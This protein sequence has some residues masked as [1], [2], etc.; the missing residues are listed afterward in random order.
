MKEDVITRTKFF[1]QYW[2]VE[3]LYVGKGLRLQE[4]GNGGWNLRNPDFHLVL[5]PLS[6]ITSEDA[7]LLFDY[8]DVR[9]TVESFLE[10]LN[11]AVMSSKQL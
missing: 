11:K 9:H 3:C 10:E 4:I 8:A 6:S 7:A 5:K 2:G 1:V